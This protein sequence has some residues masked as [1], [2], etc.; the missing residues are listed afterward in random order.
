MMFL[1][2]SERRALL[3]KNPWANIHRNFRKLAFFLFPKLM[4]CSKASFHRTEP[5]KTLKG[6]LTG[7]SMRFYE[8]NGTEPQHLQYSWLTPMKERENCMILVLEPIKYSKS[9][10]DGA[11]PT[12]THN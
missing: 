12:R 7:N 5:T 6:I 11:M 2:K 10:S 4:K 8:K 1:K 9:L 3:P